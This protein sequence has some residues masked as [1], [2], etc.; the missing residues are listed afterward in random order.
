MEDD[1]SN[2]QRE[3]IDKRIT[4]GT[5]GITKQ[6]DELPVMEIDKERKIEE[7]PA[8]KVELEN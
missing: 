3:V 6:I 4:I 2:A 7:E 8:I 1:L 5:K